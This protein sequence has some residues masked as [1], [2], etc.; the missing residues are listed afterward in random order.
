MDYFKLKIGDT[1]F[2][3]NKTYSVVEAADYSDYDV[4]WKE[5]L[6]ECG[7]ENFWISFRQDSV[8]PLQIFEYNEI[9][10]SGYSDG[11]E[12]EY[13]SEKYSLLDK[14]RVMATVTFDNNDVESYKVGYFNY[15]DYI[16]KNYFAVRK[17]EEDYKFYTGTEVKEWDITV[18]KS[19]ASNNY[20]GYI[21]GYQTSNNGFYSN[22]YQPYNTTYTTT[23]TETYDLDDR[24]SLGSKIGLISAVVFTLI[25][26]AI[27]YATFPRINHYYDRYDNYYGG[28]HDSHHYQRDNYYYR[29]NNYY[30][31]GTRDR[32]RVVNTTTTIYNSGSNSSNTGSY[33]NT[34][35]TGSDSSSKYRRSSFRSTSSFGSSSSSSS[36]RR[37]SGFRRR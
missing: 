34:G 2:Y 25:L 17:I 16:R 14:G 21:S 31:G 8:T 13:N 32:T 5:Y 10:Y 36:T 12:V 22:N 20:N 35:Y 4:K 26:V 3:K 6:I 27:I 28:Y 29:D 19:A 7:N 1:L 37:S 24:R 11:A 9:D 30:Y 15:S 33:S 23:T 18:R